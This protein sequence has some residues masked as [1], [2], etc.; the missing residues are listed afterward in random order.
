MFGVA[1]RFTHR[2]QTKKYDM[3]TQRFRNVG[4]TF[5]FCLEYTMECEAL[6]K[7]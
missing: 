4:P 5:S 7:I 3:L 1:S 2:Y 6:L